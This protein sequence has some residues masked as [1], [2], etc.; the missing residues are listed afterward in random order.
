MCKVCIN[1]LFLKTI[2]KNKIPKF[3]NL[4]VKEAYLMIK[5]YRNIDYYRNDCSNKK[6]SK[7]KRVNEVIKISWLESGCH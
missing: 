2:L 6:T 7:L 5:E 4:K 3:T 1:I